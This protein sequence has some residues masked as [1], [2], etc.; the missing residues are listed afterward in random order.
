[1]ILSPAFTSSLT[2]VWMGTLIFWLL[3]ELYLLYRD[4]NT[5]RQHDQGSR[6]YIGISIFTGMILAYM[7]GT[8]PVFRMQIDP[9][10]LVGLSITIMGIGIII[11]FLAIRTLGHHF[12]TLIHIREDHTVVNTGLYRYIRHPAYLGLLISILGVTIVFQNFL[13]PV[14]VIAM[15]L[16][17]ILFRISYEEAALCK[18]LGR[19]Y[20]EYRKETWKLIPYIY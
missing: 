12:R 2:P 17:A 11:R 6:K 13:I 14:I 15:L 9:D 8:Y 7:A 19:E 5:N 20:E 1:M 4:R 10:T 16:P 3:S 18:Q